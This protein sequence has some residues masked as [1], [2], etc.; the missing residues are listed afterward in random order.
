MDDKTF[1]AI[2]RAYGITIAEL[3]G[4]PADAER[5]R[6]LHRLLSAA[7]SLDAGALQTLADLA[8]RLNQSKP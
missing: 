8:E 6:Q 3:S 7:P 4:P 2:A 1:F 5:A